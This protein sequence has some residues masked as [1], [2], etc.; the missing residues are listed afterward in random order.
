MSP[1]DS[2][3]IIRPQSKRRMDLPTIL[4]PL[5]T[6]EFR[7]IPL[8]GRDRRA[9]GRWAAD[10][11]DHA[12]S[13]GDDPVVYALSRSG[14]AAALLEVNKESGY[15][16]YDVPPEAAVDDQAAA[17]CLGGTSPVIDVQT[18]YISDRPEVDPLRESMKTVI[19]LFAEDWPGLSDVTRYSLAEYLRCIYLQ[20]DTAVAVLTSSPGSDGKG[21]LLTNEELA[22]TRAL[23]ERFGGSGRLLNHVVV[24]PKNPADLEA[25]GTWST[26]LTCAGWKTYTM[27]V[28]DPSTG[29]FQDGSGW[30]LDDEQTGIPF[31]ER[32]LECGPR[33]VCAHKGISGF[34]PTA[35]PVDVGPAAKGFPDINFVVYH[36]GYEPPIAP[37]MEEGPYN[38]AEDKGVNRLITSLAQAGIGRGSNV[39]A[40]IGATWFCLIK[41]PEQAAH[42]LGKLLLAVGEDNLVWGTDCAW[43]GSSQPLVDAFRAFQIPQ[44]YQDRYGYPALTAEIKEKVLTTNPAKLYSIDVDAVRAM[45]QTDDLAWARNILAEQQGGA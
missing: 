29:S 6:E 34:V 44:E 37:G 7:P 42:V 5:S 30:R 32:V 3:V 2:D 17:E 26:E 43:W 33:L 41:R 45:A 11:D 12:R 18:H 19:G 4:Q 22:G 16:F 9:L 39:H 14:T 24:D 21:R 20:S 1:A 27:G 25:M 10:A 38:E 15:R 28:V 36:S 23:L 31:L 8:A 35:S 13:R 40:E